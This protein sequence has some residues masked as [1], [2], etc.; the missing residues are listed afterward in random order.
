[1][2]YGYS[3]LAATAN[4]KATPGIVH[5]VSL[6]AGADTA[7]AI[8]YDATSGTSNPIVK[9]SAVA[10]TTIQVEL[11]VPCSTGIRVA[12]TGTAPSCSV[13]YQ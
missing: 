12:L 8:V 6:T 4:V 11:H 7:T 9:L 3:I 1:M 13:I 2:T 5:F 10:N